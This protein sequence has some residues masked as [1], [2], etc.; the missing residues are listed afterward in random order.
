M[1]RD[2]FHDA[3]RTALE[4]DGWTIT[5]DPYLI[6]TELLDEPLSAD[7]G[8]EKLIAASKG[9]EKILV[10]IKSFLRESLVYEFHRAIGQI[11]SYQINMEIQDPDRRIYLAIPKFAWEKMATQGFYEAVFRRESIHCL[12]FDPETKSVVLWKK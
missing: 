11:V 7:L 9:Q 5:H 8:A 4:K 1:A 6:K 10:E 3:V 12:I 2:I